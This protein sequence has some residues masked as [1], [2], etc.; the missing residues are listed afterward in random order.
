MA[1]L[2]D[3]ITIVDMQRRELLRRLR[4]SRRAA[5]AESEGSDAGLLLDGI[6]LWPRADLHWLGV[7]ERN[8]TTVRGTS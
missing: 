6:V 8:W 7:C 5:M 1:R 2:A 3:P 4:D